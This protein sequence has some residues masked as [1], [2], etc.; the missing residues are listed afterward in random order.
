[1]ARPERVV[2]V[3][4]TGTDV[5]KTWVTARLIERLRQ[6]GRRV[7]VRKLVQSFEPGARTDAEVLAGASA[8]RPEDVCPPDR[9]YPLAM[10]PPMAAEALGRAAFTI[11]DLI[12][13]LT[14]PDGIEVGFVE[15]VGGVRSPMAC[16]GDSLALVAALRPDLVLLV[17]DAGL[18]VLNLVRLSADALDQPAVVVHLNRFD[19]ADEL[20][21]RNRK[22]LELDG[23]SLET[24]VETLGRR[25]SRQR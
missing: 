8:E 11:S 12:R 5:G 22:W 7:A 3:L 21:R 17:A 9:W 25:L 14:W 18:G 16:D 19:P 15:G 10:A 1:L 13:E 2:L 20:H 23:L 6:D 4:G 24:S